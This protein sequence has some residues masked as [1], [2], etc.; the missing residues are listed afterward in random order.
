MQY[1][2]RALTPYSIASKVDAN[3]ARLV[4]SEWWA[5]CGN[6]SEYRSPNTAG[7]P[8]RYSAWWRPAQILAASGLLELC[9][10]QWPA[11][12]S[13]GMLKHI[14]WGF[15]VGEVPWRVLGLPR[16]DVGRGWRLVLAGVRRGKKNLV[17]TW[18]ENKV[19]GWEA[20]GL[21]PL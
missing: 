8:S 1:R 4:Y 17:G 7:F 15:M 6:H 10:C 20:S 3:I 16:S 13:G 19:G 21:V 2:G 12:T 18:L 14:R 9:W 5:L 11:S